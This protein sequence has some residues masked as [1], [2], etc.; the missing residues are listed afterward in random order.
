[1][2]NDQLPPGG[3]DRAHP[4]W[5]AWTPDEG[6]ARLSDLDGVR[7]CVAA[8]WALDLSLGGQPREHSDLEIAVPSGQFPAVRAVFGGYR[9]E[10]IGHGRGWPVD[11][12]AFEPPIRRGLAKPTPAATS[13]TCSPSRM[14][15]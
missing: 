10:A 13:S 8:G 14:T 7:W 15:A 6:T 1:M 2:D 11:G 5:N 4:T 3:I 12:P 9:F